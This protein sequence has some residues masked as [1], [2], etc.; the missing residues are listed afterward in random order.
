MVAVAVAYG[1][2]AEDAAT[3]A[4]AE[5]N[6]VG[7]VVF[8]VH[9]L[10]A[11]VVVAVVAVALADVMAALLAYLVVLW[12]LYG[13]HCMTAFVVSVV[14]GIMVAMITVVLT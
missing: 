11:A 6:A 1:E 2:A 10:V 14:A 3:M 9:S 4:E 7:V 13:G 8:V 12:R 5:I